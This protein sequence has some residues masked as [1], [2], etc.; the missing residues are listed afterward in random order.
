[1]SADD[2]NGKTVEDKR[3][4]N[5]GVERKGS[6]EKQEAGGR[7][8]EWSKNSH[9]NEKRSDGQTRSKRTYYHSDKQRHR[10]HERKREEGETE[11]GREHRQNGHYGGRGNDQTLWREGGRENNGQ[12]YGQHKHRDHWQTGDGARKGYQ[13]E[14][15]G[16]RSYR[17]RQGGG[18]T[19]SS[20]S[21]AYSAKDQSRYHREKKPKEVAIP[22]A[23][24]RD[25]GVRLK[26]RDT[27]T[28]NSYR[29]PTSKTDNGETP[30]QEQ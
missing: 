12:S 8:R 1:M 18:R 20:K 5:D 3:T 30:T 14:G 22:G 11:R 7:R 6:G 29:A 19:Y 4:D 21:N 25:T 28:Q 27:D 17:A 9:V 2:I 16:Q 13:Q 10:S 24:V 15:R 23:G 26:S